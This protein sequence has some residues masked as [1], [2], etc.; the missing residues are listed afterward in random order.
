MTRRACI[1]TSQL[2]DDDKQQNDYLLRQVASLFSQLFQLF[3]CEV[4]WISTGLYRS[5]ASFMAAMT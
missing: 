2:T 1:S 5:L 3:S 4:L